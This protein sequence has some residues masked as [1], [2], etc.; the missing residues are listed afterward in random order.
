MEVVV[1]GRDGGAGGEG[2]FLGE[3]ARR[4]QRRV[5][6]VGPPERDQLEMGFA[7]GALRGVSAVE[8]C[9]LEAAFAF[10]ALGEARGA[11]AARSSLGD[12]LPVRGW[13]GE[14]PCRPGRQKHRR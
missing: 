10:A 2:A 6:G 5:G 14:R 4:R 7:F 9:R 12:Q 8:G 13:P 1:G 11:V 3:R